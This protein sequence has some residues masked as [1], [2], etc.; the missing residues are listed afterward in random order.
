MLSQSDTQGA[1]AGELTWM[2]N[3]MAF[4]K[5]LLQTISPD[6]RVW[7]GRLIAGLDWESVWGSWEAR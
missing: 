5:D 4:Y 7:F 6:R 1:G 3:S 2:G